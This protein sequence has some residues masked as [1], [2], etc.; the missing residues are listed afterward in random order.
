MGQIRNRPV[1]TGAG[2]ACRGSGRQLP[3]LSPELV[4][5]IFLSPLPAA[6]IAEQYQIDGVTVYVVAV[7]R[8][9]SSGGKFPLY[10]K[11]VFTPFAVGCLPN[12]K[13]M[14]WRDVTAGLEAPKIKRNRALRSTDLLLGKNI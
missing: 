6:K 12:G 5:E 14:Q 3:E 2:R 9:R 13:P 11:G 4:R 8:N 7:I 1:G 10:K